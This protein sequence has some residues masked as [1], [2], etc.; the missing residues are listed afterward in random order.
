MRVRK[1]NGAEVLIGG[2]VRPW[3]ERT[4]REERRCE[5]EKNTWQNA[6]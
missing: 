5:N 6:D 1:G 2:G 4:K 3:K